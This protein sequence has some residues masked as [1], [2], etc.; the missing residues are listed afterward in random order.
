MDHI[1]TGQSDMATLRL[2]H[3]VIDVAID[4]AVRLNAVWCE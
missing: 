1:G 2:A 4:F 3:F